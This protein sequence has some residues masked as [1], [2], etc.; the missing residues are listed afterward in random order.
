MHAHFSPSPN[1]A[2]K[3]EPSSLPPVTFVNETNIEINDSYTL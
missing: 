2:Y 3:I 1:F